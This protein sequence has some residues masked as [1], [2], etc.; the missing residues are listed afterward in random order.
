LYELR[1]QTW[2]YSHEPL[3]KTM[4]GWIACHQHTTSTLPSNKHS[5][6][7]KILLYF[8]E[9]P[10]LSCYKHDQKL[11]PSSS[12]I[13]RHTCAFALTTPTILAVYWYMHNKRHPRIDAMPLW[14]WNYW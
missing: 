8:P 4:V 3:E 13:V 5:H 6:L 2:G 12:L 11:P 10:S 9:L 1:P 7:V 14:S